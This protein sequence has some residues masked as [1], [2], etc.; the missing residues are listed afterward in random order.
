MMTAGE[1]SIRNKLERACA[2]ALR[3]DEP[4][5]RHTTFGAG[6]PARYFAEPGTV[7]GVVSL[8][9]AALKLGIRFIGIGKGSNLVVRD[10]GFDGLVIKVAS[11]LGGLEIR[12]RTAYV[13]AG[14]SLTRLGR[15]LTREGRPGF[16]FAVGIPGSVGGAV[17]MNAGAWGGDVAHVLK[18]VKLVDR[19]GSVN[20]M[21]A[22][23]LGFGYRTSELPGDSI[24]LSAIF[25]CPPG[26]VDEGAVRE[27]LR[28]IDTQPI[29][30]RSFG[31]TF[32]NPPGDHAA[33]MIDECGLK[34]A[35]VGNAVVSDKH[36]NFIINDGENTK[37]NDVEDL[38]S[39]IVER[40]KTR[41]DV[42]LHPEV[43][44]IGDR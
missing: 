27:A 19:N 30:Q 29:S 40:V 8:V 7:G 10:G 20:V 28:R 44:V 9:R 21:R 15:T 35:R 4:M 14:V 5:G 12:A 34:G 18:S 39:L 36:A 11:K 22:E 6:G 2:C 41:F 31:S 32:K 37:A 17:R 33:R 26:A 42:T 25:K 24:V 3:L 1:K 38:I 23:Q 43:I 13:E 16:E